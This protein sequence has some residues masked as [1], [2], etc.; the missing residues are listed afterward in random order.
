MTSWLQVIVTGAH[1]FGAALVSR[2]TVLF[3]CSQ[4]DHLDQIL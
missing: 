1:N 3:W 2:Y 4:E